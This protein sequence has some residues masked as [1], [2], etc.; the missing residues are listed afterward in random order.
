MSSL[1]VRSSSGRGGLPSSGR[2]R[3]LIDVGAGAM[4]EIDRVDGVL[5][6]S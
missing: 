1:T 3:T 6:L 2:T 4:F 5:T